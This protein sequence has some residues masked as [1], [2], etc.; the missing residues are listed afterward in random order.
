MDNYVMLNDMLQNHAD[1]M[2]YLKRYYP[3]FRLMETGFS[4]FKE[5]KYQAL[6]MGYLVMALLRFLI[7]YNHFQDVPVVY[8]DYRQFLTL[9]LKR[10]FGME[11]EEAWDE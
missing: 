7:E 11:E 3:F 9:C 4:Q 8:E 2:V 10:D 6:D 5:G 1:R